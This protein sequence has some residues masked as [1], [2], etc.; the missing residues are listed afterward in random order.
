MTS[1]R[2]FPRIRP[3]DAPF[4][5]DRL[6][7]DRSV[8]NAWQ[9]GIRPSAL[10][11]HAEDAFLEQ[12]LRLLGTM[13]STPVRLMLLTAGFAPLVS[14]GLA[15]AGV[16]SLR[17]LTLLLVI[18]SVI[19]GVTLA[20]RQPAWGR[21]ALVGLVA[22][23]VATATY[24]LL[25]VSLVVAGLWR[26][27][28]VRIGQML[29]A[30]PGASTEPA[31]L[32]WWAAGY[33]WRYL[34]D[35]GAMGAAYVTVPRLG[36]R[37]GMVFGTLI[38][39]GLVGLLAVAPQAQEQFLQ[40]RWSTALAALAGH[41]I[42]GGVLGGLA[43][44]WL[45]PQPVR[46][47]GRSPRRRRAAAFNRSVQGW[48]DASPSS[49]RSRTVVLPSPQDPARLRALQDAEHPAPGHSAPVSPNGGVI[50]AVIAAAAGCAALGVLALGAAANATVA[51]MLT[52]YPPGGPLTGTSTLAML[53]YLLTWA[54]LY[55]RFADRDL[56][57]TRS[58]IVTVLLVTTGL[59]G[60]FP[61]IQ[62]LLS[63]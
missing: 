54:N 39:L 47:S 60:T 59:L 48:P 61:P 11:L 14:L 8:L 9:A 5:R 58:L 2:G 15:L 29:L 19:A 42:Y 37:S 55:V 25:R 20:V 38:A 32:S 12:A 27:P 33:V 44:R 43:A 17:T 23:V 28:I 40:L 63:G 26:D 10:R 56:D 4:R 24:D 49:M 18:P 62:N 6:P 34:G 16:A 45:K 13:P 52:F 30:G 7:H 50:A 36:V 51:A 57:P 41:L 1:V 3:D 35:G 53:V 22:G 31:A 46:R 21:R